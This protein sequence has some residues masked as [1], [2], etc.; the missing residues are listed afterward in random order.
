MNPSTPSPPTL[1]IT[2]NG[3]A[4]ALRP[5]S[6]LADLIDALEHASDRVATAVNGAFVARSQRSLHVLCESDQVTCFQ[7][8]VG[9]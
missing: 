7:A 2:V 3:R 9:G 4:H 6:T 5:A 8:I 1:Q